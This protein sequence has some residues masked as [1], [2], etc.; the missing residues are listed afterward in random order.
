MTK[1]FHG[2]DGDPYDLSHMAPIR[3]TTSLTI[4]GRRCEVPLV[5]IFS[6]HCYTDGKSG[7]V[8]KEDPWYYGTDSTGHRAFCQSRWEQSKS[9]PVHVR[10][11][12][13]QRLSCY[14]LNSSGNFV[15]IHD[16]EPRNKFEGWYIYFSFD[17]TKE[18]GEEALVKVSVTSYHYR[19]AKPGNLRS[20][21][22]SRFQ[23]L[24][25][26]WLKAREDI[27]GKITW[28]S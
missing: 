9:L 3:A 21:E 18:E 5:V 27:L 14:R 20:G 25:S 23:S 11:M 13:E 2:P 6:H 24:L 1:E 12:I 17:R 10:G 15:R 16:Q 26:Q 28:D 22:S 19:K 7:T 8:S 4:D